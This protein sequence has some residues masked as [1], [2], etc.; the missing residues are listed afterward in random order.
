MLYPRNRIIDVLDK[1]GMLRSLPYLLHVVLWH[2]MS[3]MFKRV[4][5]IFEKSSK[6]N[7][8]FSLMKKQQ[9]T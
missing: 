3:D 5:S 4:N 8:K 1:V 6:S 2:E 9:K 7:Q